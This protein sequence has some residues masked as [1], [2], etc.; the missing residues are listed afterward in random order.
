MRVVMSYRFPI[1]N[2]AAVLKPFTSVETSDFNINMCKFESL[3]KDESKAKVADSSKP[4]SKSRAL[5]AA[6][7][8]MNWFALCKLVRSMNC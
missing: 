6:L 1:E 5:N 7:Y 4:Y 2:F 8:M 3:Q